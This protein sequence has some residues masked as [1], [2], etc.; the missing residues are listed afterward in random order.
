MKKELQKIREERKNLWDVSSKP[1]KRMIELKEL[2]DGT[3]SMIG[4]AW[5]LTLKK[6]EVKEAVDYWLKGKLEKQS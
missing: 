3:Y 1:H 4:F 5:D 6:K 2:E